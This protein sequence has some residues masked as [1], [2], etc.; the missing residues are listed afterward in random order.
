MS[1]VYAL[2][3]DGIDSALIVY[4]CIQTSGEESFCFRHASDFRVVRKNSR[5]SQ[6]FVSI[7][8][9]HKRVV[10]ASLPV[11]IQMK[12]Y[13]TLS[14]A[15]IYGAHKELRE[16]ASIFIRNRRTGLSENKSSRFCISAISL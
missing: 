11:I 9:A 8:D 15:S 5:D 10:L 14:N 2:V 16:N 12:T 6:V 7:L 1:L 4:L 13:K 3:K